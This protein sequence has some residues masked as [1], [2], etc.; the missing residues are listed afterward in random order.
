MQQI[1]NFAMM[2]AFF[3][4]VRA[5]I[6]R[7]TFGEDVKTF[8]RTYSA[9]MPEKTGEGP[10]IRGYQMKST[11]GGEPKKNPKAY[12]RLDDAVQKL[13]EAESGIATP[14]GDAVELERHGFAEKTD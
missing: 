10:R 13:A 9:A 12:G 1:H 5:S 7:D 4:A 8:N 14:T 2:D 6:A 3:D 11:G